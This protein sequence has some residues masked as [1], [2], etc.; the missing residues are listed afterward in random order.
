[1]AFVGS[2]SLTTRVSA[3][4]AVAVAHVK[5]A[6]DSNSTAPPAWTETVIAS[7]ALA[8]VVVAIVAMSSRTVEQIAVTF[9]EAT[10]DDE[11]L[12]VEVVIAIV[13][14]IVVVIVIVTATATVIVVVTVIVIVAM[15]WTTVERTTSKISE[16]TVDDERSVSEIGTIVE[17]MAAKPL[18]VIAAMARMM[19]ALYSSL[20]FGVIVRYEAAVAA[21]VEAPIQ[22]EELSSMAEPRDLEEAGEKLLPLASEAD[23]SRTVVL[24]STL[25]LMTAVVLEQLMW[26]V[27]RHLSSVAAFV[28]G[29]LVQ[30]ASQSSAELLVASMVLA[31]ILVDGSSPYLAEPEI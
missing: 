3:A 27:S 17:L 1:M 23:A 30:L 12:Q 8:A 28:L 9:L 24:T 25:H 15:A 13:I 2:K 6:L 26:L 22:P 19:V 18:G 4:A 7:C 29:A 20:V 16:A 14:V 21:V 10:V 5:L 11:G 31:S